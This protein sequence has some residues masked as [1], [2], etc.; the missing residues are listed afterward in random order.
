MSLD[1]TLVGE[2]SEVVCVCNCGDKHTRG[3]EEEYFT[4]NVP[5]GYSKMAQAAG[6]YTALWR[7]EEVGITKASQLIVPLTAGL[8][9][10]RLNPTVFK[11]LEPENKWGSYHTF[12]AFVE[13]YLNACKE[14]PEARVKADR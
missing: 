12:V 9:G 3:E 14:H 11:I 10:L 1:I 2:K 7:P 4:V 5:S 6:I 8:A 13:K